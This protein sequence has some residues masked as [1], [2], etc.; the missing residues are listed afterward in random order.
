[1]RRGVFA[2]IALSGACA[3]EPA[4]PPPE[5][6]LATATVK[7]PIP[8]QPQLPA[9]TCCCEAELRGDRIIRVLPAAACA[10]D[11]KGTCGKPER[12]WLPDPPAAR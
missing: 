7:L 8:A 9:G 6:V 11:L 12:C 10:A 1:M 3:S 2:A 4:P 5:P